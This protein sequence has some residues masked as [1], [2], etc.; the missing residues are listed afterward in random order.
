MTTKT[1]TKILF[2]IFQFAGLALFAQAPVMTKTWDDFQQ[3]EHTRPQGNQRFLTEA[4]ITGSPYLSKDYQ[5]G[6]V[7]T[8]KRVRY[9]NVPLR[10]N[11]YTDEIEFKNEEGQAMAIDFP[12]N[13]AEVGIGHAVFIYRLYQF[14]KKLLKAGYFQLMNRGKAEGLIKYRMIFKEAEPA[15]A[16]KDPQP[17][18]FEKKPATFYVSLNKKPA[19]PVKNLKTLLSVLG[20]HKKELQAFAKKE[21]IKV[22]REGDMKR[23]LNY[24][25]SL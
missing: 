17:P 5:L 12:G 13:I 22:R 14:D 2:F 24:Y 19:M 9:T 10:Y 3:L 6:Y 1:K 18:K 8:D 15:A 25:N 20:D 7:L 4:D 23:I 21:K 11:V 16:Y